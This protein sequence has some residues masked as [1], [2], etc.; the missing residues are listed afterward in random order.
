MALLR[1]LKPYCLKSCVCTP[2]VSGFGLSTLSSTAFPPT[3]NFLRYT[4]TMPPGK[5]AQHATAEAASSDVEIVRESGWHYQIEQILQEKDNLL[6][7]VCL[8]RH[9]I[10]NLLIIVQLANYS[11]KVPETR[12]LY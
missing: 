4:S 5:P 2:R 11:Q 3:V 7:H 1:I 6:Y 9:V 10:R 8:T 12:N